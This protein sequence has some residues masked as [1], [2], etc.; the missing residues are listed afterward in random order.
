M[1]KVVHLFAVL[2]GAALLT[3]RM[4]PYFEGLAFDKF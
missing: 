4:A 2:A 3:M 1:G